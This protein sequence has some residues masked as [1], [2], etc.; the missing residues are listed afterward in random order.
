MLAVDN[1]H[2]VQKRICKQVRA[3]GDRLQTDHSRVDL[4]AQAAV[5][6]VASDLAN[7][8]AQDNEREHLQKSVTHLANHFLGP[9]WVYAIRIIINV[10]VLQ[11]SEGAPS[12]GSSDVE[13]EHCPEENFVTTGLL[14]GFLC[15]SS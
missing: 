6:D 13:S 9:K 3:E 10:Q 8:K 5:D 7:A 15:S 2:N 4:V 1:N 12:E 11:Q 14:N